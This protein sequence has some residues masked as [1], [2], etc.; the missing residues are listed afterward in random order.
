MTEGR[1]GDG[2]EGALI[3]G[4]LRRTPRCCARPSAATPTGHHP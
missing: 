4:A 3:F 2:L 1:K